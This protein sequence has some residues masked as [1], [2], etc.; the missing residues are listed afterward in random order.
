MH[1][2]ERVLQKMLQF[3]LGVILHRGT[4]EEEMAGINKLRHIGDF[5]AL[6]RASRSVG[7]ASLTPSLSAAGMET[8]EMGN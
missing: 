1:S 6:R 2:E 3:D 4:A 5:T 7:R 8:P